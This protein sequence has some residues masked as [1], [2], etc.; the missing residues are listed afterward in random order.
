MFFQTIAFLLSKF[1][2]VQLDAQLNYSKLKLTFNFTLKCSYMF[3]VTNHHQGAY[4]R[5]LLKSQL[6]YNNHNFSK[7]RQ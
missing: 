3:R 4:C 5:A 1:L 6:K 7:A 2:F